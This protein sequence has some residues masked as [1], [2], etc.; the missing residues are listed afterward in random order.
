MK[1][2]VSLAWIVFGMVGCG[3]A[4]EKP[5]VV[6]ILLDEKKYIP[7]ERLQVIKSE[8]PVKPGQES[9]LK[10]K[11]FPANATR[12]GVIWESSNP[13]VAMVDKFGVLHAR[14][15]GEVM[16]SVYSW[17]DAN[18]SAKNDGP[19]YLGKASPALYKYR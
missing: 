14:K 13:E 11:V 18:P 9:H 2:Y 5:N 17:D 7:V 8:V 16:I 3:L 4:E 12:N 6:F 15:T 19:E 10:C 1:K